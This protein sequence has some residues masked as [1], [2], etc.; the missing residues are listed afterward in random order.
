MK[1]DQIKKDECEMP[2]FANYVEAAT[3]LLLDKLNDCNFNILYNLLYCDIH[4]AILKLPYIHL[5]GI[6]VLCATKHRVDPHF[7]ELW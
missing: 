4:V 5:L 7:K 2:G 3:D 6:G 1:S